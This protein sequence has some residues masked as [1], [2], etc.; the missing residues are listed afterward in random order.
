[1][2]TPSKEQMR[3]ALILNGWEPILPG[4]EHLW[5]LKS[6]FKWAYSIEAAYHKMKNGKS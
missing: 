6:D 3:E 4:K 1:M 2:T 5:Y